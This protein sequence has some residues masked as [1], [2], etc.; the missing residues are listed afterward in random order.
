MVGPTCTVIYAARQYLGHI[1]L[2]ITQLPTP[3]S[4]YPRSL[5]MGSRQQEAMYL[6]L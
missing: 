6:G 5:E 4:H 2:T 1:T 3:D